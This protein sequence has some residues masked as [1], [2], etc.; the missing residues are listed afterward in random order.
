[1]LFAEQVRI[2]STLCLTVFGCTGNILTLIILNQRFFRKT[3]SAILISALC[4]ADCIV[5]CLQSLKIV[6]KVYFPITSYDCIV[7]FCLDVSRFMSVWIVCFINLERCSLVFN[8][9]HIPHLTSRIKSCLFVMILFT[10]SLL[11][12]SHYVVHLNMEYTY[13]SNETSIIHSVCTYKPGFNRVAWEFLRSASTYWLTVP[14]CIICNI[15]IIKCLFQASRIERTLNNDLTYSLNLSSKQR[16]LTAMLVT[17]SVCFVLTATPSTV[18]AIYLAISENTSLRQ[19][20]IYIYINIL[21]H[22]H[23]AVNFLAFVFSCARFR[24]ELIGLFH[25]Y[26]CRRIFRN[27]YRRAAPSTEQM[28]MYSTRQQKTP[29]KLFTPKAHPHKRIH[30]N[31]I[32]IL[33][34]NNYNNKMGRIY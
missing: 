28:Y 24:A 26:L 23:H 17:S 14:I 29:I 16:Q 8:P 20:I 21:L 10:I 27:W 5:L 18:H 1:M 30:H 33:A 3:P 12:F 6:A 22:F 25:N 11:I 31:G 19:Y 15:I 4:I 34:A 2:I 32:V 13:D 7:F 9:C